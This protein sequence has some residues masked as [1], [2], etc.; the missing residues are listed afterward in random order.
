[1]SRFSGQTALVT[2][3]SGMGLATALRL[4]REGARVHLCGI[5]D[6]L[7]AKARDAAGD[8][9]ITVTKVDLTRDSE[10]ESW[11]AEAARPHGLDHLVNAAGIQTY[12]DLS[13]TTI[14]D[15]D[16]VMSVNLRAFFVASH[17]AWPHLKAKGKG[18]IV[19]ISS[20][21]GFANQR[22]VLGYATTK[23][24]VHAMTR[25]M[26]VDCAPHGVRV[27]SISPGSIR[28]PLLDFGAAQIAGEGGDPEEVLAMFG[29]GHPVGRIGTPEEVASLIA[30]LLSDEA[31]FVTGTDLRIDGGLTAQLG[32]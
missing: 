21:Q 18:A 31:A 1:M 11:V 24:A 20:V 15:W 10:V 4:A 3:S 12:G 30:W 5:D 8:L 26:A 28:T 6:A 22:N 29:R 9:S 14:P 19:H 7:N 25:A 32:V 2:G 13:T 23:G 27:V 17:F 16:R